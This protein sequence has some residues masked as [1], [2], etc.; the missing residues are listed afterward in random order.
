MMETTAQGQLNDFV[1]KLANVNGTG[2]ATANSLL[3]KAIFRM[4]V[5]TMGKNFFMSRLFAAQPPPG[6]C[7]NPSWGFHTPLMKRKDDGNDSARPAERL[8]H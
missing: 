8:R 7:K 6:I 5:P 2:S 3:M 1:I 4:G